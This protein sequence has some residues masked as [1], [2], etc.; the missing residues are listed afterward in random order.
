MPNDKYDPFKLLGAKAR[1]QRMGSVF[2]AGIGGL[3]MDRVP[4]TPGANKPLGNL[5][6]SG[7]GGNKA[8]GFASA[9]GDIAS[10]INLYNQE[11]S[12]YDK[13]IQTRDVMF[14]GLPTYS[15]VSGARQEAAAIDPSVAGKGLIGKGALSGAKAGLSIG[16]TFG[17]WGAAIGTAAGA[18]TGTIGGIFAKKKVKGDAED[19]KT[20]STSK[21]KQTQGRYN[22]AIGDY[23]EGVDTSRAGAQADRNYRNRVFN[24]DNRVSPFSRTI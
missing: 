20:E 22:E 8:A 19:L 10:Y 16:A 2:G 15:G 11:R 6:G 1:P 4:N 23:Y 21:F 14:G 17:P 13:E 12:F 7:G 9:A 3:P 5:F 18:I 24:I